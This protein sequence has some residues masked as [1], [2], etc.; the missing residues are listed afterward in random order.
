MR[1]PSQTRQW[2]ADEGVFPALRLA[3]H[4]GG[5]GCEA[6]SPGSLGVYV[7]TIILSHEGA[8]ARWIEGSV[9]MLRVPSLQVY[10]ILCHRPAERAHHAKLVLNSRE[11]TPGHVQ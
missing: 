8:S 7:A 10:G 6:C 3:Q 5:W 9:A 11:K 2:V 4:C 1:L